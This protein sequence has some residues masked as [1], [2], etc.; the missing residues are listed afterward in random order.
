MRHLKPDH[1]QIFD[2]QYARLVSEQDN[3]TAFSYRTF[4]S[5]SVQSNVN[6]G[7]VGGG[8][9]NTVVIKKFYQGGV[10]EKFGGV[11]HFTFPPEKM[12]WLKTNTISGAFRILLRGGARFRSRI[13][14]FQGINKTESTKLNDEYFGFVKELDLIKSRR[15][16]CSGGCER[17]SGGAARPPPH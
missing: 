2:L 11:N 10:N 15:L 12:P 7:G 8:G 4:V 9:G 17:C 6:K 1:I 16:K 13:R 3:C 14:G 5:I